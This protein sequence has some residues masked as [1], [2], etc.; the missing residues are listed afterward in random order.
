MSS[1]II[2][3][4]EY[5]YLLD[6]YLHDHDAAGHHARIV[7]EADIHIAKELVSAGMAKTSGTVPDMTLMPTDSG[8]DWLYENIGAFHCA[9]SIENALWRKTLAGQRRFTEEEISDADDRGEFSSDYLEL[10]L[11][12]II[13]PSYDDTSA[14]ITVYGIGAAME[15]N[16]TFTH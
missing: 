10:F 2:T 4:N 11:L 1:I 6:A 5:R 8:A 3:D 14:T 15:T 13:A 12:G 9:P 16:L 7:T